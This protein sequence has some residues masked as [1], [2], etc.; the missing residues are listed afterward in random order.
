[1]NHYLNLNKLIDEPIEH[2]YYSP[3]RR[4]LRPLR[5]IY[6][7]Y[8]TFFWAF[9]LFYDLSMSNLENEIYPF[10]KTEKEKIF[11]RALE[12]YHMLNYTFND[13]R[14]AHKNKLISKKGWELI[15]SQQDIIIKS[16]PKIRHLEKKIT[17]HQK[18][19]KNLKSVLKE[20]GRKYAKNK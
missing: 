3:W 11:W 2:N 9:K 7:A 1:M 6:H 19:L 14:W 13:L 4:T 20:A 5:G 15:Q 17:K 16:T 12:E 10:S 18:E 8:F